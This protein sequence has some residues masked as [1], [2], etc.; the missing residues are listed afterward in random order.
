MIQHEADAPLQLKLAANA[1]TWELEIAVQ[2]V[3]L[4]AAQKFK[5]SRD[6]AYPLIEAMEVIEEELPSSSL[7]DAVVLLKN[8]ADSVHAGILYLHSAVTG[9]AADYEH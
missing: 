7:T 5:I 8:S 9:E 1:A 6:D 3:Q 2:V 4:L